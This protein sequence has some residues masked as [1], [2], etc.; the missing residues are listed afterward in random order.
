MK[1]LISEWAAKHYS[2]APS[3][4]VLRKWC[5]DGE[6]TPRPE[7]VGR[8][9]MVEESARRITPDAPRRGLL[10]QMGAA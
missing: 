9:W 4:F 5:R 7:K 1:I 8:D 2:P 6:I 10:E 3:A